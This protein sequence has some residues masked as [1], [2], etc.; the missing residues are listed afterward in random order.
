MIMSLLA[1]CGSGSASS[2]TTTAEASSSAESVASVQEESTEDEASVAA[3]VEDETDESAAEEVEEPENYYVSDDTLTVTMLYKFVNFFSVYWEDSS[4]ETSPWWDALEEATNVKLELTLLS[5][6]V[7]NEQALLLINSGS[8]PDVAPEIGV[9]YPSGISGAVNDDIILD[10][11][12]YLEEYAPHYYSLLQQA[13][14]ETIRNTVLDGGA[15][16]AMYAL[17]NEASVITDGLWIRDDWL[18]DTGMSVPSTLDELHDVLAAFKSEEGAIAPLYSMVGRNTIAIEVTGVDTAFGS[19]LGFYTYDGSVYCSYVED[20]YREYVEYLQ[21]LANEGLF[22][23]SDVTEYEQNELMALNSIGCYGEGTSNIADQIAS[24]DAEGASF[25]AM[26]APGEPSECGPSD[27][28]VASFYMCISS[29]CENPELVVKMFDY[30][31]TEEGSMLASYGIE[32]LSYEYVGDQPMWTDIVTNNPD[33]APFA[34]TSTY[35]LNPGLPALQI[36]NI[37]QSNYTN[38]YQKEAAEIWASGFSGNA[39]QSLDVALTSD[40]SDIINN[41]LSDMNTYL[42]ETVYSWVFGGV[43]L[44]DAA[45]ESYLNTMTGSFGVD[46]MIETYQGAYDRYLSRELAA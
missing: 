6:D 27:S 2:A 15:V 13:G 45:W 43:T 37:N 8:L 25:T 12:S 30:L 32:G 19:P 4:W 5:Q 40:E 21:T 7:F 28:L 42:T 35:Y 9:I 16:G 38:D 11:S 24:I 3:P 39:K 33:G 29:N 44:D 22:L 17:Y 18:A 41:H 36:A 14:D 46:E 34:G 20:S 23:T 31:Y 1:A 10:L 26:A